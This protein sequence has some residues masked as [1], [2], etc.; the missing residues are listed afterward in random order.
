VIRRIVLMVLAVLLVGTAAAQAHPLGNFTVNH[1]T[2]AE[3]SGGEI[4]VRYVADLAE[5]P[6]VREKSRVEARGGLGP[7]AAASAA[8][9]AGDLVVSVE[10]RRVPLEPLSQ[11]ATLHP[12]AAGL[13]TL[14][15]AAWY[16][17]T[18]PAGLGAG[19]H[20]VAV[21]DE[22]FAGRIGWRELVV[23]ASSGAEVGTGAPGEDVSDELRSYPSGL[24]SR[25]LDVTEADFAW[26]RGTGPGS[27]AAVVD[28]PESRPGATEG[29]GGFAG[30]IEGD[31]SAGVI[32]I[33]L[34]LA[35]GWGALHALSPGHGKAMVAAYLVGSRGT[36]RHAVLLGAFVTITHV[37]SV[38]LFG[39]AALWLSEFI[40][41]DTLFRWMSLVAGLLVVAIGAWV[42][43]GRLRRGRPAAHRHDHHDHDHD[44]RAGAHDHAPPERL[45]VRSL[46]AAGLTAGLLPCPSAMVLLLG[47]ISLHRTGYGLLLVA[48]F[49]LGL[50]GLLTLIGLLVLYAR[51]L[52][53]RVP[54]GGRLARSIPVVS[55]LV[56]VALGVVLTARALPGL[57]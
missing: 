22:T 56:I 2:R 6:T 27:V 28:D 47:A 15:F 10:G 12:G 55:A 42:L 38:V 17:A 23:R 19:P 25:P 34:I 43:R 13:E 48:V 54:L 39:L 32:A 1:Y 46:A 21:R 52:V 9:L 24:L 40:L 18:L 30:L 5:V 57:V 14:R 20:R 31:L 45:S 33:A 16:R 36:A 53:E 44:R 41:P 8:G 49:S 29:A 3:L 51:G 26:T 4:Y 7:Y 37:T 11:V 50:A 35:L